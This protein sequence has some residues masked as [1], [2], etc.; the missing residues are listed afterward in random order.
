VLAVIVP[1]SFNALC[2]AF[3][4]DAF[5]VHRTSDR[6]VASA[7]RSLDAAQKDEVCR[8]LDKLLDGKHT[9][10]EMKGVLRRSPAEFFFGTSSEVAAFLRL[11]RD[12]LDHPERDLQARVAK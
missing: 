1:E 8:F 9:P 6:V 12:A 10:S 4:Q 5:V 7:V 3:H 2:R 11:V